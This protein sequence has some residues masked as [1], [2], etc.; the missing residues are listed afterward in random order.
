MKIDDNLVLSVAVTIG[1]RLSPDRYRLLSKIQLAEPGKGCH[2]GLMR[3][4]L[5]DGTC[6]DDAVSIVIPDYRDLWGFDLRQYQIHARFI[7]LDTVTGYRSQYQSCSTIIKA[8]GYEPN[9]LLI[10]GFGIYCKCAIFSDTVT[11]KCRYSLGI[12]ASP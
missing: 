5:A 11:S 2:P 10:F 8:R 9:G 7:L 3:N 6:G 1:G 12:G 4:Y